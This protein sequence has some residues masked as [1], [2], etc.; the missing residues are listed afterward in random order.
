MLTKEEKELVFK[1]QVKIRDLEILL[2]VEITNVLKRLFLGNFLKIFIPN[3]TFQDCYFFLPLANFRL[4]LPKR[5]MCH[6]IDCKIP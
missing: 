6:L 2:K 5:K 1:K 4:L 3:C